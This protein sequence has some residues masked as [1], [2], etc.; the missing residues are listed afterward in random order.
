MVVSNVQ[1]VHNS[2]YL[3]RF[4]AS[5]RAGPGLYPLTPGLRWQLLVYTNLDKWMTWHHNLVV[6]FLCDLGGDMG[7][8]T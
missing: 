4:G 2:V 8:G 5:L 6:Q 3:S 7:V 1:C